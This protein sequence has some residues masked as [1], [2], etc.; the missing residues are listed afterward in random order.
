LTHAAAPEEVLT[1]WREAGPDR[2]YK[3]DSEFDAL[4]RARF[5]ATHEVAAGGELAGW[6]E[7]PESAL[8][9]LIVLDQ[10]PRNIFR[11]TARA[12][13]TDPRAR[14]VAGRAIARG[15]DRAFA[16]PER[17]FFYLPFEHSEDLTDQER[18]VALCQ[19][20]GDAEAIKWARLHR[21]LIRR[22]GRFPHRNEMLGRASTHEEIAFLEGGGFRG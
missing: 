2:W 11:G 20:T 22:F 9:L 4:V 8:A 12:F 7:T 5:L 15:F 1:F 13:A 10:F 19:A 3:A 17:N 6:E 18:S 16:M 14:A 21:D